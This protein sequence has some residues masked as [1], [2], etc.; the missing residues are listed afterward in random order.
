MV[1]TP[2]KQESSEPKQEEKSSL[3]LE[4]L[5]NAVWLSLGAPCGSVEEW[6]KFTSDL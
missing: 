2:S 4:S 6:V 5:A 1:S 3:S